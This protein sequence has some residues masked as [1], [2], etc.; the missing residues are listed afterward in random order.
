MR[1]GKKDHPGDRPEN[2]PEVQCI[3]ADDE[4]LFKDKTP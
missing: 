1:R 4:G 3:V 2:V